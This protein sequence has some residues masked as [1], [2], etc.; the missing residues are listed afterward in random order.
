[1]TRGM[2][3]RMARGVVFGAPAQ[4]R[5]QAEGGVGFRQSTLAVTRAGSKRPV[6]R[7]APHDVDTCSL[8]PRGSRKVLRKIL[9]S[10]FAPHGTSRVP[11]GPTTT[12][13]AHSPALPGASA[14]ASLAC[15]LA[16]V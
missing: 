9:S 6:T 1:M 12:P 11:Y 8:Q 2:T 4:A 15:H 14:A 13:R 10:H 5:A 16:R 3:R 7:C